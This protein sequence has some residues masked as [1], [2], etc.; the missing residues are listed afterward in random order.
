MFWY[1]LAKFLSQPRIVNWLIT[2][3]MKRP[4]THIRSQDCGTVY[5]YRFWLFNPYMLSSTKDALRLAGKKIPWEFPIS[6][7]LHRIM[8]EDRDRDLHDHPWDARTIILA[9]WYF[10]DRM[11]D[12]SNLKSLGRISHWRSA[13][14][15]AKL[16]FNEYHKITDVSPNGV[17]TLFI[18]FKYRGTWGY[19]V[20]GEKVPHYVYNHEPLPEV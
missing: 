18:T 1:L 6:I 17:W 19:L 7:R 2:Q 3:A 16:S 5:M 15:T 9:G 4:Y 10:E 20:N 8:R 14:Q 11:N 13:G 12:P